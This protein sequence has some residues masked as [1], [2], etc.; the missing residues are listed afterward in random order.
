MGG[1][2]RSHVVNDAV[3]QLDAVVLWKGIVILQGV[4]TLFLGQIGGSGFV[5]ETLARGGGRF[6]QDLFQRLQ[7][8]IAGITGFA[9][10]NLLYSAEGYAG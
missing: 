2:G 5:D 3:N 1:S 10:E 8:C 6:P 4:V 9:A 7:C